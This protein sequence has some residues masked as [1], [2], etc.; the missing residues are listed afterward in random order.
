MYRIDPALPCFN[1][2]FVSFRTAL[3]VLENELHGDISAPYEV[4][5]L[6]SQT[7]DSGSIY[8]GETT[9]GHLRIVVNHTSSG[10]CYVPELSHT[11]NA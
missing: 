1:R 6:W 8:L 3:R 4:E 10:T 7:M 5:H 9:S 2:E 11:Q